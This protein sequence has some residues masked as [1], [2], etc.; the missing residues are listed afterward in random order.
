MTL[1]LGSA[2]FQI[3]LNLAANRLRENVGSEAD[4]WHARL[5]DN[6][7]GQNEI[8]FLA[9]LAINPI[10]TLPVLRAYYSLFPDFAGHWLHEDF[11]QAGA[12]AAAFARVLPL[13]PHISAHADSF[14]KIL[15]PFRDLQVLEQQELQLLVALYRLLAFDRRRFGHL[16]HTPEFISWTNANQ[17]PGSSKAVQFLR[18][19]IWAIHI[20]L[21]DAASAQLIE[22]C[23]GT[24]TEIPGTY[25]GEANVDYLFFPFLEAKRISSAKQLL[26][27]TD[28]S[29]NQSLISI[30][31]SS[32]SWRT[33][34]LCGILVPRYSPL[35]GNTIPIV[36]TPTTIRNIRSL[37]NVIRLSNPLLI[38]GPPGC[39]KTFLIE[40]I[41]SKLARPESDIVRLHLGDQTDTKL[42]VGTYSTG[43]T[44]GSFVWKQ[45]IL[46]SAVRQG[47]VVVVEDID[48]APNEVVSVLL[49]LVQ[50]RQ[51]SIPSRGE[52]IRA[53]S[54]FQIISTITE[55]QGS[56]KKDFIGRQLWSHVA[57][58]MITDDE[59][60]QI[61][62]EKY[63]RLNT[64]AHLMRDV[65]VLVR[66]AYRDAKFLALTRGAQNRI[67]SSRDLIK[68]A[69]RVDLIL[70]NLSNVDFSSGL[71]ADVFDS[72]FYEAVDTFAGS[73]RVTEARTIIVGVIG[74]AMNI[75]PHVVEHYLSTHVP[76]YRDSEDAI[77]IGRM[78]VEKSPVIKSKR[79][80][81]MQS[82]FAHTKHTLRLLEQ[83]ATCVNMREPLLLVGET[84]TGKTTV[85]Q[86]LASS[87]GQKL[88]VINV[89][90]Q[91]EASDLLGGYKPV[92]VRS[93][94][95]PLREEFDNLFE[96]TF[97]SK[98]NE[99]FSTVLTRC[100]IKNQW[101]NVIRLWKE[102]VSMAEDVIAKQVKHDEQPS[103]KRK[104][105]GRKGE[106]L[107]RM[108]SE[109]LQKVIAFESQHKNLA[110]SF[111]YK[112]ID[113]ALVRAVRNGDWVLLD[114]INLAAPD[115]LESISDL[116]I[117]GGEGACVQLSEKG[118]MEA[119]KAHPNF[120]LFGCMNPATD[121][122]KRDLPA[123]FRARFT[124][125]FVGSPD[126]DPSDLLTI[127]EKYIGQLAVGNEGEG[128][129]QDVA[130]LYL[131]AKRL[132]EEHRIVD[133]ANQKPHFSIRTLSR[134]LV[135]VRDIVPAYGLRRALYEGFCMS[136]LTLLDK[137]SEEVLIPV[138]INFT[139]ARLRNPRSV[140][141]KVPNKPG[142]GEYIKFE[143]YWLEA[144]Q[145]EPD[146]QSHY[147]I[148]PFVK[149]N[150]LNLVRATAT[151][152]FPVLIQGP[153]SSGKTSMIN[154]LA[155]KT[156]HKFVRI[157]NHEHTDLQEYLG[158]Y[159]SDEKGN[160]RFQEGVLVEAARNGY[161]I[162]LDELNLAPTDVLE[163]LNRLLDDNREIFIPE[164]QEVVKPH[165]HF[166]LFASQNPPGLY[167]GRKNLSRAFRNRFLELHFD[168]IP[169]NELEVILKD[170]CEIPGSYARRIVE[171]YKELS[172]RRQST[173]LFEKNGFATLRDLFRWAN[174]KATGTEELALHGYL[175]LAERV[176]R[177]EEQVVV[178]DVIE[179]VMKVKLDIDTFY[180]GYETPDALFPGTVWNNSMRRLYI[181]V[182][183]ALRNNEPVLLVGETGCGKTTVCQI[184][185]EVFG[186]QL[187]I[188]NAHQNTEASDIIG[189]QR[190][191]RNRSELQSQLASE[192]KTLLVNEYDN[193]NELDLDELLN[194]FDRSTLKSSNS[195]FALRI[196]DIRHR[197]NVLFEWRDGSLVQALLNG[198]F[199]L[200]DEISLTDDSVLERLNSVLEPER[201]ILLAEK[202]SQNSGVTASEGF[203]FLATMNPSGDYGKKELSPALRNRFTEI[204]VPAITNLDDVYQIV[205]SKLDPADVKFFS[206]PIV[207]FAVWFSEMYHSSISS[208]S[209]V[210]SLRDMLSW[211]SFLQATHGLDNAVRLLHGASMVF[212]D[213]LGTNTF[214]YLAES[215]ELLSKERLKCIEYLSQACQIDLRD[216]YTQPVS[217]NVSQ[218]EVTAGFFKT[219]RD[220]Y[221][222]ET[223]E[224]PFSFSAPT[225]SFNAM[226]IIRGMQLRKPI[227]LEGSPGV[228]KTS[229]MTA[230]AAAAGV[231]FTRINL[232]DQTDLM[233]LFGSDS[234]VEGGKSGEFVWRDAPF[235][236]AMQH[237]HWVLLDE[238]NLASQSVLEGLNAC[239]DHRAEAYI[240]ELDRTFGCHPK[241]RVFAAQNSHYQGG[242]R[243]GLP[244]SFINRFTVV[245]VDL[246]TPADLNIITQQ[247]FPNINSSMS[248]SIISFI[249]GLEHETSRNKTLGR[250]G[251]P[252]EFNLRDTIR[253]F[254][255]LSKSSE[256]RSFD[257]PREF[258]DIV[259]KLRFR[260]AEDR[261]IVDRIYQQFF[262]Q[263]VSER[264]LEYV[265][266]TN[267]FQ[268]GHSIL[269]RNTVNHRNNKSLFKLSVLQCDLLALE[270]L[271]T[272]VDMAWPAILV[273]P[274]NSGKT[275]L[276]RVL[277]DLSGARLEEF[278]IN[279]DIDSMDIVGGFEQV[280]FSRRA[281]KLWERIKEIAVNLVSNVYSLFSPPHNEI[282]STICELFDLTEKV[283]ET[284][285]SYLAIVLELFSAILSKG[286]Q[287][288][289]ILNTM[290]SEIEDLL[291]KY[292][293]FEK[294]AAMFEWFDGILIRAVEE[295]YW[296]VLDNANLCGPSVLDRLNSLLEP[297]GVLVINERG[298]EDGK[299]KILKPHKNFR[300]FLTVNPHHGELSRAM[301]N[302]GIEIYLDDLR[303]RATSFD[304]D[305]LNSSSVSYDTITVANS[306][307]NIIKSLDNLSLDRRSPKA[308][309]STSA[310][311]SL[312]EAI[313][314][315]FTQLTDVLSRSAEQSIDTKYLA[316]ANIDRIPTVYRDSITRWAKSV[317]R[318]SLF[319]DQEKSVAL[320][321]S[322]IF[323]EFMQFSFGRAIETYYNNILYIEGFG[324]FQSFCPSLNS[325]GIEYF[326]KS[327]GTVETQSLTAVY[328][329]ILRM[330]VLKK[331]IQAIADKAAKRKISMLNYIERSAAAIS[332][333]R[334]LN[335]S[336]DIFIFLFNLVQFLYTTLDDNVS[337]L[338][339]TNLKQFTDLI[340]LCEDLIDLVDSDNVDES[341]FPIYRDHL[342]YIMSSIS[343]SERGNFE[344]SLENFSARLILTTGQYMESIWQILHP[345]VPIT[346]EGWAMYDIIRSFIAKL[347]EISSILDLD[348]QGFHV[349]LQE[350]LLSKL[351]VVV[352]GGYLSDAE[353]KAIDI[354]IEEYLRSISKS[355]L[356]NG[357]KADLATLIDFTLKIDEL[358]SLS[359]NKKIELSP[360][361][362]EL[363]NLSGRGVS[364]LTPYLHDFERQV[365]PVRALFSSLS[366]SGS[367]S[368]FF[369][370]SIVSSM[371]GVVNNIEAGKVTDVAEIRKEISFVQKIVTSSAQLICSDK[372]F[373]MIRV[374]L[375]HMCQMV[376][377][378]SVRSNVFCNNE[379]LSNFVNPVEDLAHE[380][381]DSEF[382]E[383]L[384]ILESLKQLISNYSGVGF[385]DLLGK[386]F[387]H[388]GETLIRLYVPSSP[389]DPAIKPYVER[390]RHQRKSSRLQSWIQALE[391]TQFVFTGESGGGPRKVALEEELSTVYGILPE[392]VC[393]RPP[394]SQS[395]ALFY[396]LHQFF[397]SFAGE[398]NISRLITSVS[399][400]SPSRLQSADMF[401]HN[402]NQL[403]DRLH[404]QFP[405]YIDIISPFE[406]FLQFA[407][408]GVGLLS[409]F[410][411]ENHL[412]FGSFSWLVD[413]S[414]MLRETPPRLASQVQQVSTDQ[415]LPHG[416][417]KDLY[418]SFIQWIL[419][420]QSAVGHLDDFSIE[421][422][423]IVYKYFYYHWSLNKKREAADL[424]SK[425]TI[426]K[427]DD[428]EDDDEEFKSMFPD[429]DEVISTDA[430]DDKK[431]EA[432]L[433][434]QV[435]DLYL[436][437]FKCLPDDDLSI[438]STVDSGLTSLA[439]VMK[440][441]ISTE[442]TDI[443][444]VLPATV[445]RLSTLSSNLNGITSLDS[446]NKFYTGRNLQEAE[447]VCNI[448]L[449]L[450][451]RL[452]A[453]SDRWPE[454]ETLR[455][456]ID[457]CSELLNL[458]TSTP[459]AKF[460]VYV[461][462]E[463]A[464]L[465]EWQKVSS[466]EFSVQDFIDQ[467]SNLII[468]WRRLELSSWRTMFDKEV[469][470]IN[471]AST[472]WLFYIYENS[473]AVP[474]RLIDDG[475]NLSNHV[476][477]LVQALTTFVGESPKGQLETRLN[478]IRAVSTHALHFA[479]YN[480]SFGLINSSMLNVY[481]L[482]EQFVPL[483]RE[484]IASQRKIIEKEVSETILLA[485]W[486]DTNFEALKESA[487][488]SHHKL[489]KSVRKFRAVLNQPVKELFD[490]GL[491]DGVLRNG[492]RNSHAKHAQVDT[493][494]T[495]I[496][497]P[498]AIAI[499]NDNIPQWKTRP[500]RLIDLNSTI[501]LLSRYEAGILSHETP[502]L[503][504]FAADLIDEMLQLK[505]ETP[506][507]ATEE[508]QGVIKFLKTRKAKLLSDT[509]KELRRMGLKFRV[510][511]DVLEK[512]N[513]VTK[514]L[515]RTTQFDNLKQFDDYFFRILET[516]PKVRS[517][518]VNHSEDL[519]ATQS[520][521]GIGCVES[522][523]S[524]LINQRG[525]ILKAS[526]SW[527]RLNAAVEE[528]KSMSKLSL[529][530]VVTRLDLGENKL[531][532]LI[533]S[534]KRL[535]VVINYATVTAQTHEL[536]NGGDKD[537]NFLSRL[538]NIATVL[539]QSVQS[540]SAIE[541]RQRLTLSP[542]SDKRIIEEIYENTSKACSL[543]S[544]ETNSSFEY[545]VKFVLNSINAELDG[546]RVTDTTDAVISVDGDSVLPNLEKALRKLSDSI[547]VVIQT[548]KDIISQDKILVDDDNWINLSN[549]RSV[550]V[551]LS[552]HLEDI[553]LAVFE[554]ID[555]V[556]KT[557]C[558]ER[559]SQIIGTL[560]SLATP[561]LQNFID[562]S[563][564]LIFNI[565]ADHST[566]AKASLILLKI[567]Q[568]VATSGYCSPQEQ[569]DDDHSGA[570]Q[571][572][573]G[574]GDGEG[575]ENISKDVG[576]DENLDDL[577]QQPNEKKEK[578]DDDENGNDDAVS[579]DGDM[580]GETESIEGEEEKDEGSDKDENEEDEE[581]LDEEVGDVDDLDASAVDEKM[582][583]DNQV[584]EDSRDKNT[585]QQ[586][587][588]STLTDDLAAKDNDKQDQQQEQPEQD[589][590]PEQE[591][592][593]EI[594]EDEEADE[595]M[596]QDD[597]VQQKEGEDFEPLAPEGDALDLPEDM[598]L[599]NDEDES[600]MDDNNNDENDDDGFQSDNDP[601]DKPMDL[602]DKPD[603]D[604]FNSNEDINDQEDLQSDDD[605]DENEPQEAT[606]DDDNDKLEDHEEDAPVDDMDVDSEE[607][608]DP[609]ADRIDRNESNRDDEPDLNMEENKQSQSEGLRGPEEV[610]DDNVKDNQDAGAKGEDGVEDGGED[611]DANQPNED[612]NAAEKGS[613]NVDED[614]ENQIS[615][616]AEQDDKSASEQQKQLGDSS[617]EWHRRNKEIQQAENDD[618]EES[619][620]NDAN[621]KTTG[622]YR[623]M[624]EST[625]GHDTQAL[626]AASTDQRQVIE[627]DS[628]AIDDET[629]NEE[630]A[631]EDP[632]DDAPV[633]HDDDDNNNNDDDTDSK[634]QKPVL[635]GIVGERKTN[636]G[637][638]NDIDWQSDHDA[639]EV[640][641][642]AMHALTS[643]MQIND[644]KDLA[645]RTLEEARELWQDHERATQDLSNAL[646]EQLRLILEPTLS[647]KLRGDF[648]TGKRLNMKRIIPYIA[649]QYKKDK[650]WLRRT[651]PSKR[652]YQIMIALDDS[653]SMNESDSVGLAFDTITLVSKALERLEAGQVS[654]V[655]FGETCKVVHPFQ[656]PFT[657]ESGAQAFQWFGFDQQKT[658]VRALVDQSITLFDEAKTDAKNDMWQLE[659]I[660]SDGMC[661]DHATLKRL[662]RRAREQKIM[663]V[664]IIVDGLIK[665]DS[666]S[667]AGAGAGTGSQKSN[668]ITDINSI[669]FVKDENGM[670][671]LKMTN[672]L[673]SFPFEFYVIVRNIS[674]LPSVLSLVLRQY[675]AEV[676]ELQ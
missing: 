77:S 126:Q 365:I 179:K 289:H 588:D 301:R 614:D 108:W 647:T 363:S 403:I 328:D 304:K 406:E 143:H 195:E 242:G 474:L 245:Y 636:D 203:Q 184:L 418:V 57:L 315:T 188:V 246:L 127:V 489:Y 101:K 130:N 166:L 606:A 621:D 20:G 468:E 544:A 595:G 557:E 11:T 112:F 22:Q 452:Q 327:L 66:N 491:G 446:S 6:N 459:V 319:T 135:Y 502:S 578:D 593:E 600:K 171:V 594:E 555:I 121:V 2:D 372:I 324:N 235:L 210:V 447:K 8:Q 355:S 478:L 508:N 580:A 221:S 597:N 314:R 561:L 384:P 486:K 476:D 383:F 227:M 439:T 322:Q 159:V 488:R 602:N 325:Y 373:L 392:P 532:N 536:L 566:F 528:V 81:N 241:F 62:L 407:K 634:M 37:A 265:L 388:Y 482:Y 43:E 284:S 253:W 117:E 35:T 125:V 339:Q 26:S 231:E 518:G 445:L 627:D 318:S 619:I 470:D 509:L 575:A 414:L 498:S 579:V 613:V 521:R 479:A 194:L 303:N 312:S 28:Y 396:E 197:L 441:D 110:N 204:W 598:N 670:D 530:N 174:R 612:S 201:S 353:L 562:F 369:N 291:Q 218:T 48:K 90:Q 527:S 616:A 546:S 618:V 393:Y 375:C 178:K 128:A 65:Y 162:V 540:A 529:D 381:R 208:S 659:I 180:K 416:I 163:A 547:L 348:A 485:S 19:Q 167:G 390:D 214:A 175:L 635:G 76:T 233:D 226:R 428:D 449:A 30:V 307:D 545:I 525:T 565:A 5:S 272:C 120:R 604:E 191:L 569:S 225:T 230:L 456:G 21:A 448:F 109:F 55:L 564:K 193:V 657:S 140:L 266:A 385:E 100:F 331:R 285:I 67:F 333:A 64:L 156:G 581:D 496:V 313:Y 211:I 7:F 599:D 317:N 442:S 526:S 169:E 68:W 69:R 607:I 17:R 16:V 362:L 119:V 433:D 189:A 277:A 50:Q 299:L 53:G 559:S 648:R 517:A 665:S 270:T 419:L 368:Q 187:H 430:L 147:I 516:L 103:K 223:P 583:D 492:I 252:W 212:I 466:R 268:I 571:Q 234:P 102:A 669:K 674:E 46:A 631:L 158:S 630:Q 297:N 609:D 650:I 394:M 219:D 33:A 290:V 494:V 148:T 382:A 389:L 628:M 134:T 352:N 537:E 23:V 336:K 675:F 3:D 310:E 584:D 661:D 190:P 282:E 637:V 563:Q 465:Y 495:L 79:R 457:L 14:F 31:D 198:D 154:Y 141:K 629:H 286:D 410:H 592:D 582:W 12:V 254:Q 124:E 676:A 9:K 123:G 82:L 236:H 51:I 354:K 157:N 361:Y 264:H 667:S 346:A 334:N 168:D 503:L 370:S 39:G 98:R 443:S 308:I 402:T 568:T 93:V 484:S 248:Q 350:E 467:L 161:W 220:P 96:S 267:Y 329:G 283:S 292:E 633:A 408:I 196:T 514:V 95:V 85:V 534:L 137:A 138:I 173:R 506:S 405:Y 437:L 380:V 256:I 347:G 440:Q 209:A 493:V 360:R 591:N 672:Y 152:R 25:E 323:E 460:L 129:C 371:V 70:F 471:H 293:Q 4:Q 34:N 145:F 649:S 302:R 316:F 515:V 274:S 118:D 480:D 435:L 424:Q 105:E 41:L 427:A 13:I 644:V 469:F 417:V 24:D 387:I 288:L 434:F 535:S 232:S 75:A 80:T 450:R 473:I 262:K 183:E 351:A 202:G 512:Q 413:G 656:R 91:T 60:E 551:L 330:I 295:G 587:Q 1:E 615:A 213:T 638:E 131:E 114:E 344:S 71:P 549:Q 415:S 165:P 36:H 574:L 421:S 335:P 44:P 642:T 207:L 366:D 298:L 332:R 255:L 300:L 490:A 89:S 548:V 531:T 386:L 461:E 72:V 45:G 275:S 18:I 107:L 513:A 538:R 668:S 586:M 411:E 133:G 269:S 539:E 97:S 228:G 160:L 572:G 464:P 132:A 84:G 185:A 451:S 10:Y 356:N 550:K 306:E 243:K 475:V 305:V 472:D 623:H 454:V 341:Q 605:K 337:Q 86:Q 462:K 481:R 146:D 229:I 655:R 340:D 632:N 552:L 651:K 426:Y 400:G 136:F 216:I 153:T 144:G 343:I 625:A 280:D 560:F 224:V 349:A 499:C 47:K 164:T 608:D 271:M 641:D 92:D 326:T 589:Q 358:F 276:I 567:F 56:H 501:G 590:N 673:D 455:D 27:E 54:E 42:L 87:L 49:S 249:S 244:A 524:I 279:S 205:N 186:K 570:V 671:V 640:D 357:N 664:F 309:K 576:E 52:T 666:S 500:E 663:L 398:E 199:F 151:R 94:A 611:A 257:N 73:I 122:G 217:V 483:V 438:T 453:L 622:E 420:R 558:S 181:L 139:I 554:A 624:N 395:R 458:P 391:L 239:L 660:I 38:T 273:G 176:R 653:K 260:T 261:A 142:E 345:K 296:L 59:L 40:H 251:A 182:K 78:S 431:S 376:G 342:E 504:P 654:I 585:D 99:R 573:T 222:L 507:V 425:S 522:L 111:V 238:M 404:R 477:E 263:Q 150:L 247:L 511:S 192:L 646:C 278:A 215:P 200:L 601:L 543:L 422:I 338:T 320:L 240:P 311:L 294:Q 63:P 32:L 155:K 620:T 662:A 364:S 423:N 505:K 639:A 115:T 374:F 556:N 603:Q 250:I 397:E 610:Q 429:Y 104:L 170:R 553:Y 149:K 74:S 626:G 497:E 436:K 58:D 258:L 399:L 519:T 116:L 412:T 510:R 520:Q 541:T 359:T 206:R 379:D 617:Q 172:V 377:S 463:L 652:E 409:G 15:N 88:V 643:E 596:Q 177:L 645:Y 61:V 378:P 444:K 259:V 113:G 523:L 321:I 658:D 432:E 287:R 577:A 237:G 542:A 367:M 487:K 533:A 281:S 29:L 401:Q 83:I 106:N